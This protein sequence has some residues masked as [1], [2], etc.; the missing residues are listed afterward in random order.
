MGREIQ[1]N[2]L[3][4]GIGAV[5]SAFRFLQGALRGIG[6]GLDVTGAE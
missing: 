4:T 3:L 2:D 6:L 1:V 5:E